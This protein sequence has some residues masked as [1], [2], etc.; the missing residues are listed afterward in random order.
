MSRFDI[1]LTLFLQVFGN[2]KARRYL[3]PR[4]W[5]WF[6]QNKR[7]SWSGLIWIHQIVFYNNKKI[8]TLFI[9]KHMPFTKIPL[10]TLCIVK[11]PMSNTTVCTSILYKNTYLH[12][13]FNFL[14][15]LFC[16]FDRLLIRDF[17]FRTVEKKR[18]PC[19]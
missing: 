10:T 3:F 13:L 9:P 14:H 12:L 17:L 4:C 1:F 11:I 16:P 6:W 2:A 15:F 19:Y 7:P 5:P 18:Y 8:I